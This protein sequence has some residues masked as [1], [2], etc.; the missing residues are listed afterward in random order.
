[1]LALTSSDEA[2]ELCIQD[3]GQGFH[4]EDA[5][6]RHGLGLRVLRERVEELRG[7]LKLESHP[8]RG[9]TLSVRIPLEEE[10]D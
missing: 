10:Y 1:M 5:S 7:S 6:V 3:N 8:G 9:T 2:V 4:S